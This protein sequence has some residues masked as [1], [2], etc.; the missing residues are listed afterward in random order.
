MVGLEEYWVEATV[1]VSKLRWINFPENDSEAGPEVSIRNRTAW[2]DEMSRTGY[3]YKIIG[4][5]ED[6]TRLARVLILCLIYMPGK[7]IILINQ[8]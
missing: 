8:D 7:L 2:S 4:A 6:Q 3:L 5:L 1:P